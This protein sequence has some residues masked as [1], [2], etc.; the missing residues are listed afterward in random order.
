MDWAWIWTWPQCLINNILS[1]A[2]W[3]QTVRSLQDINV[4]EVT[5]LASFVSVVIQVSPL[6]TTSRENASANQ[7]TIVTLKVGT[8]LL[9]KALKISLYSLDYVKGT[10]EDCCNYQCAECLADEDCSQADDEVHI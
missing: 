4:P 6:H 5:Y 2:K 3:T 8:H 10:D 9:T 1:N 7:T